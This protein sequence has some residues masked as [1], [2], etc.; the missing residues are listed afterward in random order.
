MIDLY[1]YRGL[2]AREGNEIFEPLLSE[3]APA[4]QRGKFEIDFSTPKIEYRI[5]VVYTES[6]RPGDEVSIQDPPTGRVMFGVVKSF[7][8]VR[9]GVTV[10]TSAV[11]E[12]PQ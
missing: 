8:H 2:G 4:L 12:A 1:V 3:V 5:D 9:D 11:V 7:S 10:F 6:L